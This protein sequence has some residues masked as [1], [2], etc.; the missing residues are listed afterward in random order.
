MNRYNTKK[1]KT[2]GKATSTL[3]ARVQAEWKFSGV[4]RGAFVNEAGNVVGFEHCIGDTSSLLIEC[5]G[6][7]GSWKVAR[8]VLGKVRNDI[9]CDG[10]C[11]SATG[12]NCECQCG[13]KNHGAAHAA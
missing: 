6:G 12:H 11:M 4:R 9:K 3:A 1:C 2:C 13:G 10:R 7:C 8:K 5:R